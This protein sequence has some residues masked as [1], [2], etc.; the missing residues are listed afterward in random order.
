[1]Y[2]IV[3]SAVQDLVVQRYGEAIWA[4][5]AQACGL[6]E[7]DIFLS[8]QGYPDELTYRLVAEISSRTGS[9]VA[10]F[11]ERLGEFWVTVTGKRHYGELLAACGRTLPEVLAGI[12][13]LHG[14]VAL[15][16]PGFNPPR[17]WC[18]DVT[19]DRLLLHYESTREG[20]WPFV[21]G[22]VRALA[23]LTRESADARLLLQPTSGSAVFEV[24]W[25]AAA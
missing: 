10:E 23:E 9:P 7:E 12:N 2:G 24:T 3:N 5:I 6:D 13:T 17:L 11:L 16:F 20:L 4:E 1:M 18:S 8:H 14:R 22:A 19:A 25:K 15:T 21:V